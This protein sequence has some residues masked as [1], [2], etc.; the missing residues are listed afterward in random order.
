MNKLNI[1]VKSL[2]NKREYNST[3]YIILQYISYRQ[4]KKVLVEHDN[5]RFDNI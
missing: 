5:L 2:R 1:E 4:Y 3:L